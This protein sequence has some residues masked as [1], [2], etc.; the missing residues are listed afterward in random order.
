MESWLIPAW[1]IIA[2][3]LA[4]VF[5]SGTNGHSAMGAGG[6]RIGLDPLRTGANAET[7]GR[8]PTSA[9]PLRGNTPVV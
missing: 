7:V 8:I 1:I 5:G 6:T 9:A 3:A 4:V 2:P